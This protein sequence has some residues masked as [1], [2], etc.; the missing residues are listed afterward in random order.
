MDKKK[1][2]VPNCYFLLPSSPIRVSSV[3][4]PWLNSLLCVSVPLWLGIFSMTT[5][6]LAGVRV[7]D[8]SRVL[9]GPFCGQMLG[10]LGAEVVK[11]ERP[12][13]GDDTR[14]WGPPFFGD[15]SAYFLSCNRNK[16]AVTLDL[17]QPDGLQLFYDLARKSDVLLENF[18]PQSADKLGVSPQKL[19]AQNPRL[20]VCS[21][22]GF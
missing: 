13:A 4:H 8:A 3:F 12:G 11:I 17:G 7:L 1:V 16:K 14:G 22:S 15:L 19:L 20:I 2:V 6:P 9:A 18:R 5:S 21:I 10:D